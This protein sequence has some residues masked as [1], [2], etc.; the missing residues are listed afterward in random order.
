MKKILIDCLTGADNK[1]FDALRILSVI[2]ILVYFICSLLTLVVDSEQ[3]DPV[4]FAEGYGII[5]VAVSTS[6]R[7]KLDT[8]KRK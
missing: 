3:W 6:L 4:R 8:E 1:T 2:A 7:I 5:V